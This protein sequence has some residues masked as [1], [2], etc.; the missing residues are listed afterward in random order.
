MSVFAEL[1][2][3]GAPDGAPRVVVGSVARVI[4]RAATCD[5]VVD[6][7]TISREHVAVWV[8]DG[9]AL[10]R[11]L[12]S[13]NGT[14]VN[15]SRIEQKEL[16]EGDVLKLG[17]SVAFRVHVFGKHTVS[18][19]ARRLAVED[20]STGHRLTLGPLPVRIGSHPDCAVRLPSGPDV[21]AV[22]VSPTPGEAWHG[23]D[24]DMV[25]VP[26][27]GSVVVEGREFRI[28]A[29]ESD[30]GSTMA[31]GAAPW[32]YRVRATLDAE[33]GPQAIVEDSGAGR[34][35]AFNGTNRAVLLYL[36]ARKWTSD[37]S[38]SIEP[39]EMG[40]CADDDLAVGL[41]GRDGIGR[42]I[43]VLVCRLR[44][45][46]REAGFDPWFVEKRR[47]ALRIRV[48]EAQTE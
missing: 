12:R 45:E 7:N 33:G 30:P 42:P 17:S 38:D 3:I 24:D 18:T 20:V 43:K 40:W 31:E 6:R 4:G 15:D 5:Y 29:V 23:T 9:K 34:R 39:D 22:F 26:P 27:G 19:G 8:E 14:F 11:D 41:W 44:A 47:G 25:E 16:V 48:L 13:R 1:E 46:L 21:A 35:H 36:L 10:V 32:P 37:R 28:V 2:I